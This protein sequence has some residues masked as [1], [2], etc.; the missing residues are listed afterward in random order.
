LLTGVVHA[1]CVAD[2]MRVAE[3]RHLESLGDDIVGKNVSLASAWRHVALLVLYLLKL[4]WVT[5]AAAVFG[6]AA[7]L[8]AARSYSALLMPCRTLYRQKIA[9]GAS[10]A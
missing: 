7:A 1:M 10:I 2:I 9:R 3:Q 5:C 4:P 6:G 8:G